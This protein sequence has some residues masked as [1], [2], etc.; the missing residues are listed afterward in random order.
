M[1]LKLDMRNPA[2]T[3]VKKQKRQKKRLVQFVVI[4]VH[5]LFTLQT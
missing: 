1:K 5:L 2:E 4:L 3:D